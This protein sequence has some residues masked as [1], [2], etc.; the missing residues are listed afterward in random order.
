[1]Q[2]SIS[3]SL[4]RLTLIL[5]IL[6]SVIL[7]LAGPV[8]AA[9]SAAEPTGYVNTG[10]LNIRSGPYHTY[11]IVVVVDKG[12]GFT[13]LGRNTPATW[14]QVKLPSGTVGW[15]KVAYIKTDAAIGNLPVTGD[16][17]VAATSPAAVVNTGRLNVRSAPD[18]YA[19]IL[20]IVNKGATLTLI[21][22]NNSSTWAQV[23]TSNGTQGWVKAGY[24]KPSVAINTLPVTGP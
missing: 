19:A 23:K 5:A 11:S 20:A 16:A 15:A 12:Q 22:R 4:R 10:R 2:T 3:N 1:M 17:D 8:S 14:I 13:I 7:P 9:P 24:L 21:G 6:T 18:P